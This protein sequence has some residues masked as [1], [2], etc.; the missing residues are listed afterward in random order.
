M[1][2]FDKLK[3]GMGVEQV[4]P[5]E[6]EVTDPREEEAREE[7]TKE[8]PEKEQ[9]PKE[10][11]KKP[12][13]KEVQ[14]KEKEPSEK[15]AVEKPAAPAKK[16]SWSAFS[17]DGEGQLAVDVYQTEDFLVIQSAIAGVK[18]ESL[19]VVVEG[20]MVSI[21]GTREKPEETGERNYFYQE[22][23]W[24]PFSRQIIVSVEIDSSRT[25]AELKD[26]ILTVKI[27]KIER[28]KKRKIAVRG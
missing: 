5:E 28:D 14:A 3:K 26:G 2:F 7:E 21:K 6:T 19:D 9:E 11:K 20:D 10:E 27:P 22:C 8:E 13:K 23:F 4:E 24:G 1:S 15:S 16:E 12:R 25:E 18:P 17:K